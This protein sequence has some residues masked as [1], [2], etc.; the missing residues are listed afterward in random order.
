MHLTTTSCAYRTCRSPSTSVWSFSIHVHPETGAVGQTIIIVE[1]PTDLIPDTHPHTHTPLSLAGKLLVLGAVLGCLAPAAT[2]AACMSHR[3]PFSVPFGM[4][5]EVERARKSLS[6][7][8]EG[9][10]P[11]SPPL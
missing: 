8:G 9:P 10:L 4:R 5:E 7:P 2:M 3:S 1:R 11:L 6:A